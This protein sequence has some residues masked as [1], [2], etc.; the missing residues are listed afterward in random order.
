MQSGLASAFPPEVSQILEVL[1]LAFLVGLEREEHKSEAKSYVFGGVRTFPMIG[2]FGYGL[3]ELDPGPV[4]VGA[5]LVVLAS[6]LGL[7]Y[8]HKLK[9]DTVPGATT[10]LSGLCV[11]VIGALVARDHPWLAC[12]IVVVTLLLLELKSVLEGLARRIAPNEIITFAKFLFL[13]AVILPVVPNEELTP[14][15]LNPFKTWLVVVAV[16][17]VSYGG[18]LVERFTKGRAGVFISALLGGAYS[19]TVTTVV[20]AKRASGD[21]AP[22]ELAG[23]ILAASGAMYLRLAALVAAFNWTLGRALGPP[24]LVLGLLGVGVGWIVTRSA[25]RTKAAEP[26]LE[27]RNPL[28]LRTAFVFALV[29]VGVLV[30]TRLAVTQLGHTGLYALAA[31]MGV[32]DV[33]PFIMGLTQTADVAT[34]LHGAAI[35]VLIAAASNNVMKGFY[36]RAFGGRAVGNLALGLLVGLA[37]LGLAAIALV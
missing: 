5:G 20:L 12:A 27:E 35:A 14:F 3:G 34:P 6:I 13:S 23:G 32:S 31:V 26:V 9:V 18:Y 2:L 25:A 16:S 36:A 10:E 11:Y 28:D 8:W 37:T 24:L 1:F 33:D 30:L 7:S 19:S 29:F 17:A 22:R 15:H 4:L 21:T